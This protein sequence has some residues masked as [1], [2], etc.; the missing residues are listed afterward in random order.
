[1]A[2]QFAPRF[3]GHTHCIVLS[4]FVD[5]DMKPLCCEEAPNN[6]AEVQQREVLRPY[7]GKK[8]RFLFVAFSFELGRLSN[9]ITGGSWVSIC[10]L[11]TS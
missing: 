3:L 1:M 5:N 6:L 2:M 4:G 7:D 10:C 9:Y 8:P 11:I